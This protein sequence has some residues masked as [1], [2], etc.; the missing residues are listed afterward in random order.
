MYGNA[1]MAI[2]D[3]LLW[4][5][6]ICSYGNTGYALWQYRICSMAI[7]DMLYGNTGYALWQYRICSYG[8]TGY[9][10]MAN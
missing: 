9:A 8:N 5:Y 1:P 10:P 3:M 6:R 2:E 7:E 4:Q